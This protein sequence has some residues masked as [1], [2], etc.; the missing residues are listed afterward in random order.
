[1]QALKIG[2]SLQRW[3]VTCFFWAKAE[4]RSIVKCWFR[5][6]FIS[7]Q[8]ARRMRRVWIIRFD[9]GGIVPDIFWRSREP[10]GLGARVA[11]G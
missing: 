3:K 8:L 11:Q 1:M 7:I 5:R 4:V 2:N 6:F 10:S 9:S